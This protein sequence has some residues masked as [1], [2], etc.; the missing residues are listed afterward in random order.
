ML[1]TVVMGGSLGGLTAALFLR[2]TGCRVAVYERSAMPLVGLVGAGIVL[3]PATVR[4]FDSHS[5][6]D[7]Q[8]M[9][10][11]AR[12]V[13]YMDSQGTIAAEQPCAYRFSS[14]NS[15]YRALLDEFRSD[16]YHLGAAIT[17]FDQDGQGVTAQF[18]DG[19][20]ERCDLLVCADGFGSTARRLLLPAVQL[21]YAGY[22]A[23]RGI[24]NESEV[25]AATFAELQEAIT[26]HLMPNSHVLVYPIPVMDRAP[27]GAQPF[28]NWLW[29]R[30]VPHGPRLDD[31]MT[32]CEGILREVSLGPGA[33]R[34]ENV[35]TLR[36][37][38]AALLPQPLAE[39]I[40]NTVQPFLQA[41]VDCEAPHMAFG[42]LCLI[43]DA[44]FVARPHAAAGTAK[45][46]EDGWQLARALRATGG[47][48]AAALDR[49]EP[50]QLALGRSVLART[51]EAGRR[52]QVDNAWRIG[53]PLPFGLYTV[54]DST[55]Q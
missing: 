22:V 7:I 16:D 27:G 19:R 2:E 32:D 53:D 5:G 51:R 34:E 11:S 54:G 9:S 25:S 43:G 49:W 40:L 50:G 10:I 28:L 17:G 46:A 48:V 23:W 41:I 13:R 21:E 4:Y 6:A 39:L 35:A 20:H 29:Y 42:R 26:Y 47:Q 37:E 1:K 3:N 45:A 31:L 36:R 12:W 18:D 55:M 30:N 24:V 14:Y 52:A 33:V 38:A 15:I 8:S 44:A